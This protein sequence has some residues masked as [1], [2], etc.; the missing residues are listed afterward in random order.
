MKPQKP[1]EDRELI[2]SFYAQTAITQVELGLFQTNHV[3]ASNGLVLFYSDFG[4]RIT[5]GKNSATVP[6]ENIKVITDL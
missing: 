4:V 5:D 2:K 1:N 6:Y 3:R